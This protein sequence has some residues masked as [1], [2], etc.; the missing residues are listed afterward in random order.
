M[1]LVPF[2]IAKSKVVPRRMTE[3]DARCWHVASVWAKLDGVRKQVKTGNDTAIDQ[4]FNQTNTIVSIATMVFA[5]F[6]SLFCYCCN[7]QEAVNN[8]ID[9]EDDENSRLIPDVL[10]P[11]IQYVSI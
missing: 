7:S 9:D 10:E 2:S 1:F 5:L 3:D 4:H 11:S 8:I 6:N